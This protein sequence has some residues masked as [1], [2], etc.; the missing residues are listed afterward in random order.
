VN[1]LTNG[2]SYSHTVAAIIGRH[3]HTSPAANVTRHARRMPRQHGGDTGQQQRLGGFDAPTS[4]GGAVITSYTDLCAG[5]PL[6]RAAVA[7]PVTVTGLTNGVSTSAPHGKQCGRN[8]A[9]SVPSA[10]CQ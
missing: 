2:T 5:P 7:A 1:G 8:G 6:S 4:N 9:S 10:L 3:R